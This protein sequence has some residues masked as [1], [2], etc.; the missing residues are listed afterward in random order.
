SDGIL[1]Q[2]PSWEGQGPARGGGAVDGWA[3]SRTTIPTC[4]RGKSKHSVPIMFSATRA[5]RG[6]GRACWVPGLLLSMHAPG[7][8]P[9]RIMGPLCAVPRRATFSALALLSWLSRWAK[10][11]LDAAAP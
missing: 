8:G 9:P 1:A 5:G 6:R 7:H 4:Q 11:Q 10:L 3:G 2:S